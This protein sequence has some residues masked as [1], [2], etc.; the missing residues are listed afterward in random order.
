[1]KKLRKLMV[2]GGIVAL[3]AG[4]AVLGACKSCC[5]PEEM[6]VGAKGF[7]CTRVDNGKAETLE[8]VRGDKYAVLETGENC[9]YTFSFKNMK[10]REAEKALKSCDKELKKVNSYSCDC[11]PVFEE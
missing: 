9:E 4:G 11:S 7:A 1:M 5:V 2:A 6:A 8:A 10:I 3:I